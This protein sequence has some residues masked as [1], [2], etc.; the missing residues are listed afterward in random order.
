MSIFFVKIPVNFITGISDLCSMADPK[1]KCLR[2][3]MLIRRLS[4]VKVCVPSRIASNI[5][6]GVA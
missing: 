1:N 3:T 6:F 5:S 4:I 2:Q